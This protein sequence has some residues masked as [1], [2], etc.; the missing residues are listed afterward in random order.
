MRNEYEISLN[1]QQQL[2]SERLVDEDSVSES[3][4]LVVS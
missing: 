4:R 3:V 1:R 2:R